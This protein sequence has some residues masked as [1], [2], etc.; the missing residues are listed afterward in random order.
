[1]IA[2]IDIAIEVH[3]LCEEVLIPNKISPPHDISMHSETTSYYANA[4]NGAGLQ[5]TG[6][7]VTEAIIRARGWDMKGPW[8]GHPHVD[9]V[10]EQLKL[11][12]LDTTGY[13]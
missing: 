1:M 11:D 8:P 2:P 10:I 3:K 4:I 5:V 6:K 7:Q 13:Y 9:L 12:L